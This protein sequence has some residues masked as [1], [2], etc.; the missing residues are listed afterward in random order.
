HGHY[1]KK[2]GIWFLKDRLKTLDVTEDIIKD[3]E[4]EIEQI[5]FATESEAITDYRRN[6]SPLCRYSTGQCDFYDICKPYQD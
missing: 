4:F 6:I 3:A 5:H 2:V 1:P